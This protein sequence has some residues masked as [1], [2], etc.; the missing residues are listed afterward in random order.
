[1]VAAQLL[2]EMRGSLVLL[3]LQL[4][5][6][7]E[8]SLSQNACSKLPDVPHAYVSEETKRAEY[9]EGHVIYFTC[10]T[11]Y[12][13]GPTIRYVCTRNGWLKL[14]FSFFSVKPCELPDD[15]PNGYYQI[16]HGDDFVFGAVIKYFCNEGYMVSKDNTRT[17]LLDKWTNHVPIC[18]RKSSSTTC[19]LITLS[20]KKLCFNISCDGPGKNLNG[21]SVLIC[22][23]D[24]QWDNPFPTCEVGVLPAHLNASGLSPANETVKVGH[25]LKFHCDNGYWL[26][27]SKEIQCLQTGQW[28]APFPTCSGIFITC[29]LCHCPHSL[30]GD[31]TERLKFKYSHD[32]RVEYICQNYYIMQGGPFRTCNNGHWT[33]AI[34]CLKPCTVDR[35]LMTRHNIQFKYILGDKLRSTH[36]GEI[37][38]VCIRGKHHVGTY[39]MR[40]RCVDGEMNLPSCQ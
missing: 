10:E 8:V 40:Q 24:G 21:S 13:S 29:T 3:F 20:G 6:N 32:E 25:R 37:E 27:G 2:V 33:G 1:V 9:E 5:G 15:T 7:V 38:F 28:N 35:Q 26:D 34:R 23:I 39:A 36:N 14:S 31:T 19:R 30:N 17:C 16:I 18:D 11:G 22:G 4:W 12:I